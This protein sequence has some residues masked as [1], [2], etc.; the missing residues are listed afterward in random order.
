MDKEDVNVA[1]RKKWSRMKEIK[2]KLKQIF[3]FRRSHSYD[4]KIFDS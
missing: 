3:T 1:E 2:E 4:S